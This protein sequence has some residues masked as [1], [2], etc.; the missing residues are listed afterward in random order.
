MERKS[1][2]FAQVLE[3]EAAG[4]IF[5]VV[6]RILEIPREVYLD[7]LQEHA[8]PFSQ[9]G[10]QNFVEEYLA[11]SGEHH[12]VVGMVRL[13]EKEATI[14]LDAAVRYRINPLERPTCCVKDE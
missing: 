14:I 3:K 8:E 9:L 12:G 7:V 4:E 6:H 11:W 1:R 13:D 10:A 2:L 5:Q